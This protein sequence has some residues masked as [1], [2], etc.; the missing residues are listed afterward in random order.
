MRRVR[1]LPASLLGWLHHLQPS[2]YNPVAR[3]GRL[4]KAN[5]HTVRKGEALMHSSHV[6]LAVSMAPRVLVHGGLLRSGQ[7]QELR[8]REGGRGVQQ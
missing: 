4:H 6:L 5:V 7:R 1:H 3:E 8:G 2:D